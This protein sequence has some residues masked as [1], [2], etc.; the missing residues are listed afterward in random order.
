ML[1]DISRGPTATPLLAVVGER[2]KAAGKTSDEGYGNL[3]LRRIG[4]PEELAD[5]FIYLLSDKSTFI[6]G[7]TICVDGGLVL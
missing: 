6:T 7:A 2:E 1:T 3:S 4:D 5:T